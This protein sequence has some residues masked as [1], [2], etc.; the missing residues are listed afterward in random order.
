MDYDLFNSPKTPERPT[1]V[2]QSY[3]TLTPSTRLSR[4]T[5][6]SDTRDFERPAK[7]FQERLMESSRREEQMK[8]KAGS[9]KDKTVEKKRSLSLFSEDEDES[10]EGE[11]FSSSVCALSSSPV[12][13]A[14]PH[15]DDDMISFSNVGYFDPSEN[16]LNQVYRDNSSS[17]TENQ[18]FE[19]EDEGEEGEENK[20]PSPSSEQRPRSFLELEERWPLQEIKFEEREGHTL[21][22][23]LVI[24]SE[25]LSEYYRLLRTVSPPT[26]ATK[27]K[28]KIP[29]YF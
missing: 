8:S 17:N 9:D 26:V 22:K 10:D 11:M 19:T 27:R 24:D 7:S 20:P 1:Y 23:R 5:I 4:M 14:Y 15:F 25:K 18:S 16:W 29:A 12:D 21:K 2:E 13:R 6:S 3:Q 28:G